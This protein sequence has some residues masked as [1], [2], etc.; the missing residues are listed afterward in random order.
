M[1]DNLNMDLEN[2]SKKDGP[3]L[4]FTLPIDDVGQDLQ[5]GQKGEI[6]LPVEVTQVKEGMISFRK[7]G[8][9]SGTNF[10]QA[11]LQDLENELPVAER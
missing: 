2:Q 8:T 7:R 9:A 5:V 6:R 10:R 11:S 1:A 4:E 3:Q